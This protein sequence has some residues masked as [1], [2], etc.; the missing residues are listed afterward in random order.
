MHNM[1]NPNAPDCGCK[2][3][4]RAAKDDSIPVVFNEMMNEYHLQHTN[5]RGH[6]LFYHCPFCGGKAPDSLRGTY[7][8]E[9]SHE[10]SYRLQQLTKDIKTPDELFAVLGTPDQDF[11]I[12][13]SC[14]SPG[15]EE[16]PPEMV[17]GPRRV[18][19]EGLSDTVNVH[20]TIDRYGRLKFSYRGRYIGPKRSESGPGE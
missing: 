6:S 18:V 19:Y 10:E 7:W 15:S 16:E 12:G 20:V 4:D 2:W 5:G 14:T 9:V 17:L 11:E 1:P 13:G 3:F 8:T